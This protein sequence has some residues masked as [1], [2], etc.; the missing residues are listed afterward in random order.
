MQALA[1]GVDGPRKLTCR[2]PSS[3]DGERY[4]KGLHDSPACAIAAL[5][6]A[7]F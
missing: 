2:L 5:M 6:K 1:H 4:R 3:L 7:L